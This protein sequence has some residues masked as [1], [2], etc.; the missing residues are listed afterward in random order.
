MVHSK[1]LHR[2]FTEMVSSL[3]SDLCPTELIND[4]IHHLPRPPHIPEMAPR[5][6]LIRINFSL[7][8]KDQMLAKS[9]Y[10]GSLPAPYS[11]IQLNSDLSQ[12]KLQ[13][14]WQLY[15]ITK[16]LGNHKILYRWGFPS[17][18]FITRNGVSHTIT[19]LYECLKQIHSWG[20]IFEP[21][22]RQHSRQDPARVKPSWHQFP[23]IKKGKPWWPLTHHIINHFLLLSILGTPHAST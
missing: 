18:L 9:R 20:I 15:T 11:D 19:S 6:T 8:V 16:A 17:R 1:D 14:R 7:Y 21:P 4:C 2:Y 22:N 5:D 12:Y 23:K 3:L 10:G 13:L